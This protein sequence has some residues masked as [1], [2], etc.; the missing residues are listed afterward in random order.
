VWWRA[1]AAATALLIL[2]S[3]ALVTGTSPASQTDPHDSPR[4]S[5]ETSPS[6]LMNQADSLAPDTVGNKTLAGAAMWANRSLAGAT[7]PQAAR[8]MG[9]QGYA[10]P[11]TNGHD[12]TSA[13]LQR[14]KLST[15]SLELPI[16]FPEGWLA[17]QASELLAF[18][19]HALQQ[20]EADE[21]VP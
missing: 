2:C 18:S 5:P 1:H 7:S 13:Q 15:A 8:D 12:S 19:L 9:W 20:Q 4:L 14:D 16:S 3:A 10:D 6:G 21:Q 11:V 17:E